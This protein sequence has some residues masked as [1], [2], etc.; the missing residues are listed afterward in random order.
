MAEFQHALDTFRLLGDRLGEADAEFSLGEIH[1]ARG[2]HAGSLRHYRRARLAYR[3]LG[4]QSG[5]AR[6]LR[7]SGS[8]LIAA[9]RRK[10]G[11]QLLREALVEFEGVGASAEADQVR[12]ELGAIED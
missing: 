9:G 8:V 3:E 6:T 1:R 10:A 2:S 4:D 7:H 5:H 12:A 11:V